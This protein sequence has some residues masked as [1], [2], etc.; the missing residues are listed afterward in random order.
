ML[1]II[2]FCERHIEQAAGIAGINYENERKCVDILPKTIELPDFA[3]FTKN[4]LGVAAFNGDTMAGY[5]CC[6]GPWENA[7]GSTKAKGIWSPLHGNGITKN[8]QAHVFEKMYQEAAKKWV[9]LGITSH[10]IT[11]YAHNTSIQNL[12]YRYGFGLRCIDAIRPM[13]IINEKIVEKTEAKENDF[14][15]DIN[16]DFTEL[17]YSDFTQILPL[18]KLLRDHLRESPIFLRYEQGEENRDNQAARVIQKNFR[19]FTAGRNREIIAYI[20]I[21]DNGENFISDINYVKNICGAYCLPKYRGKGISLKLLN[22]VIAKLRK[23]KFKLLGVD[24]ESLNPTAYGFWLK[25]FTEY[26]RSVVRRTDDRFI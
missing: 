7:F 24:F 21:S 16:A 13:E 10:S 3:Q 15:S 6:L 25:Y 18:D 2:D 12:L 17:E 20:K 22:Y 23:E 8:S 26:T 11:L 5:L 14:N 1:K 19:Y 9:K 4:G